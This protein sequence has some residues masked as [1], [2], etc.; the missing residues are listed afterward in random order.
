LKRILMADQNIRFL[1]GVSKGVLIVSTTQ[2][3]KNGKF[4][5][6]F[7]SPMGQGYRITVRPL[8]VS[9]VIFMIKTSYKPLVL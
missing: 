6:P 1:A 5:V 9:Q 4:L 2:G 7:K 8:R 3:A